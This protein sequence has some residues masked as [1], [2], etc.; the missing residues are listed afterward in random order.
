MDNQK[1]MN[2]I[3]LQLLMIN[4]FTA[5]TTIEYPLR[6]SQTWMES[7]GDESIARILFLHAVSIYSNGFFQLLKEEDL[8]DIDLRVFCAMLSETKC[9]V[10]IQFEAYF[11]HRMRAPSIFGR[12]LFDIQSHNKEVEDHHWSIQDITGSFINHL[13]RLLPDN[14]G[15][16]EDRIIQFIQKKCE[17]INRTV[18]EGTYYN[19][20]HKCD[21]LQVVTRKPIWIKCKDPQSFI[22]SFR[23]SNSNVSIGVLNIADINGR[24]CAS[25]I[26][27]NGVLFLKMIPDVPDDRIG[28]VLRILLDY[29][30]IIPEKTLLV[31]LDE[32]CTAYNVKIHY[33]EVLDYLDKRMQCLPYFE[34][35]DKEV[36]DEIYGGL[37]VDKTKY[38]D[39]F[40]ID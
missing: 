37:K 3:K 16:D 7:L 18:I 38:F 6:D 23:S 30:N 14:F 12:Y 26:P 25:R 4:Q 31:V 10:G 32:E 8:N 9:K 39:Y 11:I 2:E 17:V 5:Q 24:D 20:F 33:H 1:E 36:S 15:V 29:N 19:S 13:Q 35:F 21:H 40:W 28:D 34:I 27:A 22:D